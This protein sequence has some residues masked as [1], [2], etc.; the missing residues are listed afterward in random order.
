MDLGGGNVWCVVVLRF[1]LSQ[2]KKKWGGKLKYMLVL[3]G[4]FCLGAVGK[5]KRR[6]E[7]GEEGRRDGGTE[8]CARYS[9]VNEAA[10]EHSSFILSLQRLPARDN[11]HESF[12]IVY[13]L[14]MFWGL[15]RRNPGR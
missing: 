8:G 14:Q 10:G 6:R 15:S 2:K 13:C 1:V 7:G 3:T 5:P 4:R 9:S 12:H 11:L